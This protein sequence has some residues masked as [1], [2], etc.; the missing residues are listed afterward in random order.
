[1]H[2]V[3]MGNFQFLRFQR[4]I[5]HTEATQRE[6]P[7]CLTTQVALK[8]LHL[9]PLPGISYEIIVQNQQ[10]VGVSYLMPQAT[11]NPVWR[12]LMFLSMCP[13]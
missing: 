10:E 2:L 9:R 12:G 6:K 13:L 5:V 4:T 11:L 7:Q 1:M 3:G 8:Y